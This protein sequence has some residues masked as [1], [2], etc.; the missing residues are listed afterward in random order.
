MEWR[1]YLVVL[2]GFMSVHMACDKGRRHIPL[3]LLPSSGLRLAYETNTS[4][5]PKSSDL[6]QIDLAISASTGLPYGSTRDL[7]KNNRQAAQEERK[8]KISRVSWD[9]FVVDLETGH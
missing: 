5:N 9:A 6:L 2:C 8:K 7:V 3:P 1:D 4:V